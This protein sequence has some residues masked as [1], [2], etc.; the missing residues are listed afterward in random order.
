MKDKNGTD[1]YAGDVIELENNMRNK[2]QVICEHGVARRYLTYANVD[3]VPNKCDIYS[4]YFSVA[5]GL[6]T[7]PIVNNYAG[8]HDLE[9][10]EVVG[11]IYQQAK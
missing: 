3:A 4:F 1:I 5:N 9:L 2:I 10:F 7:F 8:K 6:K 11:N